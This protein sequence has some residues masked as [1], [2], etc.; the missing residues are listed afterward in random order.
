MPDAIAQRPRY[1]LA[2]HVRACCINDQVVLLDLRRSKYLGVGGPQLSALGE[3]IA[4]WPAR[5]INQTV[6]EVG[7]SHPRSATEAWFRTLREQLMLTDKPTPAKQD[8]SLGE[9][10]LT[11]NTDIAGPQTSIWRNLIHLAA[12]ASVATVWMRC[13]TLSDIAGSIR[14]LRKPPLIAGDHGDFNKLSANVSS[15]LQVRPF[16]L[17]AHDQCLRDSLTL[18]S[19]LAMR[20]IYPTWVIG[21]K[22]RPFGAH[23]WVQSGN[24]V[25]NDS[26]DYV[27]AYRP[28]LVV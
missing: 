19:F 4:D 17:T 26:H 25:L 7:D 13:R 5:K 28:I 12:A 2:D 3:F 16:M 18:V 10:L 1:R 15:Y 11:L 22:T 6:G 27:R 21:V 14:R 9:P 20:G 23:S 24:V 8:P